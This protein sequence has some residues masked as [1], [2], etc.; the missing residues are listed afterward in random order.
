MNESCKYHP[1]RKAVVR[2]YR[3]N[4]PLCRECIAYQD[5]DRYYCKKCFDYILRT[6]FER[7]MNEIKRE[8]RKKQILFFLFLLGLILIGVEIYSIQKNKSYEQKTYS[9][10]AQDMIV[11][12]NIVSLID[13]ITLGEKIE[14]Y[15][16]KYG[17]YPINLKQ[18]LDKIKDVD[19]IDIVTN[20]GF[21]YMTKANGFILEMPVTGSKKEVIRVSKDNR[22]FENIIKNR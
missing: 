12:R 14:L 17:A 5:G 15:K 19:T 10:K 4:A 3:C 2:C 8:V 13:F 7:E 9:L 21:N 20:K 16:E 1:D 18:L 22:Y 11:K 6:E